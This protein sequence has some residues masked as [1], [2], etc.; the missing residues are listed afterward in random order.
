MTEMDKGAAFLA[1]GMAV[2]AKMFRIGGW[3]LITL[4]VPL[5]LLF[6]M[7]L[8]PMGIGWFCLRIAKKLEKRET[9]EDGLDG[10]A[11]V[12]ASIAKRAKS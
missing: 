8:I 5:L 10:I 12:G 9:L 4:G 2:Q 6:G 7:G 1:K 11:A 3:V